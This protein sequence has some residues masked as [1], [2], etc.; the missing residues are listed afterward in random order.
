MKRFAEFFKKVLWFP[1]D[2]ARL[3]LDS[4]RLS[5]GMWGRN[6]NPHKEQFC[7][8]C[9]GCDTGR[10]PRPLPDRLM[11]Y[12]NFWMVRWMLPCVGGMVTRR[13][14][15]MIYGCHQEGAYIVVPKRVPVCAIILLLMWMWVFYQALGY[16]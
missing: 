2:L 14:R 3:T 6:R 9:R 10:S 12:K 13:R 15:R 7:T 11:A 1:V 5:W 16:L 4:W 8:F